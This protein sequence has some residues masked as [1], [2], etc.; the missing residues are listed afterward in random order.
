MSLGQSRKKDPAVVTGMSV[1]C[2][3]A[4]DV[5]SFA[6]ALRQGRVGIEPAPWGDDGPPFGA[7]IR[8]FDLLASLANR[9]S[10][11]NEMLEAARKA[12]G[13]APFPLQVAAAASLEAWERAGLH[14]E[15]IPDDR[16]GLIVAG[17]NLN[18]RHAENQRACFEQHPAYLPGKFALNFQDTDHVGT[19]S[20]ILGITGEGCTVGGASASGNLAIV[21]ASRL[22][23]LGAVDACLVV[24]ALADL[25]RMEIQSF[26]NI[27][28]MACRSEDPTHV[29][30]P[31][32][33]SH[34]GFVLGQGCACLVLESAASAARRGAMVYAKL[35]GYA[36]RLDGNRLADPSEQGEAAVMAG[37]IQRAD[38]VPSDVTYMNTHGSGSPLGDQIELASLRRVFGSAAG[39]PWLNATKALTGHCL[40]A[41]AV[42]EAVATVIQMQEGFLH[43]N[44][45][46]CQPIDAQF[47]FTGGHAKPAR[48][49][50]A[51]SNSFGFGGIN[52]SILFLNP[53]TDGTHRT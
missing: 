35:A 4:A 37:A 51:Q 52:S 45:G 27:G 49:A 44:V 42:L 50:V 43:P 33:C 29:A 24:G 40:G 47:R 1:V 34:N 31:F 15:P 22:I 23:E 9:R 46:L 14:T 13:R 5:C 18:G 36:I 25:S 7:P 2:S 10:L 8:G 39:A 6:A 19:L 38:L 16:L 20:Q 12:A 17:N 53:H 21:H 3:I 26:L 41:A 28:A 48:I 11:P 32:D 30:P